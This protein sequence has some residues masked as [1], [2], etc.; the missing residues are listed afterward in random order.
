M[1]SIIYKFRKLILILLFFVS[2]VGS[3]LAS[4]SS[5]GDSLYTVYCNVEMKIYCSWCDQDNW[6][7]KVDN[8]SGEI[9]EMQCNIC[10]YFH[11]ID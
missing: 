2:M 11:P 4:N 5:N 6:C 1:K 9:L 8:N 3:I 7:I 10:G